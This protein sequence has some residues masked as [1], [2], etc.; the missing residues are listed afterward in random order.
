MY[1][2]LRQAYFLSPYISSRISSRTVLFTDIPK[3]YLGEEL[4]GGVFPDV[5]SVWVV[6]DTKELQDLIEDRDKTAMKLEGA[7]CKLSKDADKRRRRAKASASETEDPK[8]WLDDDERPTHRLKPIIGHKVDTINWSREHLSEVIPKIEHLQERHWNNKETHVPAAFVEFETAEAAEEAFSRKITRMPK[9]MKP[10]AIGQKPTQIIWK[11]LSM[12][13]TQ[14]TLRKALGT[15]FI[16]LLIIF[17]AIPVAF[18]GA[19]SNINSLES[20]GFLTW[21][22]DIPSVIL[23]VVTGLL[24]T[25]LLAVLMALVPI[26]IRQI[27]K[28][29]GA[30]STGEVELYTQ[31]WYFAFQVVQVFLVTTIAS[32]AA[33]VAKQIVNEPSM[34]VSLL[35]TSLPTASNFYI[36]FF[37]LYGLAVSSKTL[38]NVAALALYILLGKFLDTTPRKMLNRYTAIPGIKWGSDYP[39]YTNL[40][41]IGLFSQVSP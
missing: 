31:K 34:A 29:S 2:K 20:I 32:G 35:A 6:T 26:I 3:D 40:A 23:G 14:R 11:N 28:L 33:A 16:I 12:T 19:V 9:Q 5:R 41:V 30:C 1:I 24:P 39:V 7:E 10:R 18:V 38:F 22:S 21:I 8:R 13:T 25:I 36:N 4:L 15:T 27:A 17:W 37:V